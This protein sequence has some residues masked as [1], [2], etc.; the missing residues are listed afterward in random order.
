MESMSS[1]TFTIRIEPGVKKRLEKVAKSTGRSRSSLMAEALNEYLY[2]NE[3]QVEG[4]KKAA[5]RLAR[6]RRGYPTRRCQ[7]TG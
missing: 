3:W 2:V 5:V 7:R 6:S 1:A 4:V